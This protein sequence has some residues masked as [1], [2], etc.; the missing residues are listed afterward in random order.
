MQ[1]DAMVV[2]QG[3][4]DLGPDHQQWQQDGANE[5]VCLVGDLA[6]VWRG[7]L[8]LPEVP[9]VQVRNEDDVVEDCVCDPSLDAWHHGALLFAL[10]VLLPRATVLADHADQ[11]LVPGHDGWHG[12]DEAGAQ[13]EVRQ[14]RHVEQGRGR[15]EAAGEELGLNVNG[16]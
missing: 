7:V 15:A 16:R 6:R 1:P 8:I 3:A 9:A 5:H 13:E 11:L 2:H 14:T 12:G 4:T 10:N